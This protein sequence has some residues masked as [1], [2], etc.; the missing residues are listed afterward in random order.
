MKKPTSKF[1]AFLSTLFSFI[2]VVLVPF[3]SIDAVARRFFFIIVEKNISRMSMK[4]N[5]ADEQSSNPRKRTLNIKT[6]EV[7]FF[8]NE[9]KKRKM[10]LFG[11]SSPTLTFILKMQTCLEVR[12]QLVAAGFPPTTNGKLNI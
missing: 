6:D 3:I 1:L 5:S 12:N 4:R 8:R 10:T 11:T 9:V 2:D 7:K